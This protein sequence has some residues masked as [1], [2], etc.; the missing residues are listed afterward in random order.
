MSYVVTTV[1][2]LIRLAALEIGVIGQGDVLSSDEANDALQILNDMLDSWGTNRQYIYTYQRYP[3]TAATAKQVYTLGPGGDFNMARP[4]KIDRCYVQLD[5]SG[6][7]SELPVNVVD[8]DEW[9]EIVVKGT[10]SPIARIVWPDYQY[11][12]IN[13]S[14]WPV[15]NIN[16]TF[17]FYMRQALST[18]TSINQT[19]S[20]PPGYREAI[21]LMLAIK[22][23]RPY[24]KSPSADLVADCSLAQGN[25]KRL[26]K[27]KILM[28]CDGALL[29][30]KGV[31]NYL[32]GETST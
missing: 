28:K 31:F 19:L 10:Q 4:V 7:T 3:F 6:S 24:E 8:Y 1:F 23:C 27:R 17:I 20:F 9:A 26:N 32:T 29:A 30:R 14:F 18:L 2:D 5:S 21:R 25:I 15:P 16:E 13:L 11:P 12:L 22:L